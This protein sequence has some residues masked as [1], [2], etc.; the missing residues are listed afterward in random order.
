MHLGTLSSSLC[1]TS[2][3]QP[4]DRCRRQL[5]CNVASSVERRLAFV[6]DATR[7]NGGTEDTEAT[8]AS[9]M[10]PYMAPKGPA[11]S[12]PVQ[13]KRGTGLFLLS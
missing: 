1:V 11:D 10:E 3:H 6:A 13:S 5:R 4:R 9:F 8:I 7:Q 12:V 2:L